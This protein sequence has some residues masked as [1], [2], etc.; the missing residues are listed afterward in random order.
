MKSNPIRQGI[1]STLIAFTLL[2]SNVAIASDIQM[3]A[4][5]STNYPKAVTN[6]T[7]RKLV[8]YILHG[9]EYRLYLGNNAPGDANDI[10]IQRLQ[11]QTSG[12]MMT[13]MDALLMA[14]GE[15]NAIVVDHNKRYISFTKS[16]NHHADD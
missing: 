13:R 5:I 8:E 9:T 11:P 7:V 15:D 2:C 1:K 6:G 4:M 14:I 10:V 12:V 3:R 16:V